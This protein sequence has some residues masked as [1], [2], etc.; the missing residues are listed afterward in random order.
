M[1]T[2]E[3]YGPAPFSRDPR[4]VPLYVPPHDPLPLWP[5]GW[6]LGGL[7]LALGAASVGA[8]GLVALCVAL[9]ALL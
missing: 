8:A 7:A 4:S 1:D 6:S 5:A 3:H 9:A 2:R